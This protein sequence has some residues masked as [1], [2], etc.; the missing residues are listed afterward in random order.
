MMPQAPV[1]VAPSTAPK[2][3]PNV[4]LDEN[5]LKIV[6]MVDAVRLK[7]PPA[8]GAPARPNPRSEP[9]QVAQQVAPE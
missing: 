2:R 3:P 8:A 9:Q 7:E 6:V 4:L 1:M 5:K